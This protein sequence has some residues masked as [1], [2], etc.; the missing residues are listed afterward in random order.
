MLHAED[1]QHLAVAQ[2]PCRNIS[3][4]LYLACWHA[5]TAKSCAQLSSLAKLTSVALSSC[6][7]FAL[8]ALLPALAAVRS[9]S[10]TVDRFHGAQGAALP[11]LLA[12]TTLEELHITG[13]AN[14]DYRLAAPPSLKVKFCV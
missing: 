1:A 2:P 3:I 10:S 8:G 9:L 4:L 6:D 7:T 5:G 13:K 14:G 12:L 11:A